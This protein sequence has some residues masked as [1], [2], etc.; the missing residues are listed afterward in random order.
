MGAR[1]FVP[2]AWRVLRG[3]S[4]FESFMHHAEL[5]DVDKL[6][7]FLYEG[8]CL[9]VACCLFGLLVGGP[10][11]ADGVTQGSA[12]VALANVEWQVLGC[13]AHR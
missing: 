6:K 1:I 13:L 7:P 3:A 11:S 10:G 2:V 4:G 12:L 5:S 9:C 8:C